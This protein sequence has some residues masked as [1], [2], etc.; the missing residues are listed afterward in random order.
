MGAEQR[1]LEEG[2]LDQ[3]WELSREAFHSDPAQVERWKQWERTLGLERGE[4]LL[5]DGRLAAIA[6]V[7]PYAQWFGGRSVPM[8]GVRA[9]MVRTELRGRGHATRVL[10][11][12]LEAMHRRG[13][14]LSV[15]YPA[16]TRPYRNLGWETAGTVVFRQVTPRVL[17]T[18]PPGD[19]DVRRAAPADR[20]AVRAI[21]DRVARDTNG[22]LDRS[23]GRWQW[24]LDR[25]DDHLFVAGDDGYVLYRVVDKPPAGPE[26]FRVLVLDLVATTADAWRSL[27]AMLALA[28]SV[29]PMVF[30]RSGPVEPLMHAI[31][32][33]D[34]T[35]TRERPWMLRLVDAPAAIAARGYADDVRVEVPLEI[36][37]AACPWNVG[38]H[39]LVV[40]RGAGWLERGG[41]GAVRLGIGALAALY[42]GWATT[43]QLARTGLLDPGGEAHRAGLDR[44]FA[45][46]VP[47]LLDEF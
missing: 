24:V 4:G 40:E 33:L 20:R 35:V 3:M 6:S 26:G 9:V 19:L 30:L 14:A 23:D 5:L 46:P 34:V 10:R 22:W 11:A 15:L 47:W 2:D 39:T 7:L 32:T 43:A 18:I 45:G 36:T 28:S 21:Y 13:E 41:S 25:A 12:C 8:G 29:V 16:V 42:S 44:A 17:A 37:D 38:R 1:P 31:D 27:W